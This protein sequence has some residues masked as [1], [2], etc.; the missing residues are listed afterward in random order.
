MIGLVIYFL[1]QVSV[2]CDLKVRSSLIEFITLLGTD[3]INKSRKSC[4]SYMHAHVSNWIKKTTGVLRKGSLIAKDVIRLFFGSIKRKEGKIC[5]FPLC[6]QDAN[7][8][9][10]FFTLIREDKNDK[11]NIFQRN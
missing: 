9:H 11:F 8:V 4:F 5:H 6:C 10:N 2:I 7:Y 3:V 1:S